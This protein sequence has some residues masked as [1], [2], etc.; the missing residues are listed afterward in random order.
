[1]AVSLSFR[2]FALAYLHAQHAS[3]CYTS[4]FSFGDSLADTGNLLLSTGSNGTR[5]GRLPYGETFFHSPTGRFSDGRLMIDFIAQA[6]GLPFVRPYLAGGAGGG[7]VNFAV[8]GA[9][10]LDVH[11]FESMGMEIKWTNYSL[12]AQLEWFRHLL[13]SLCSSA[14]GCAAFM[15]DALFLVGE[16]G[17]NDYNH[18][19]SAGRS[20]TEITAMVP[21]VVRAIT[22]AVDELIGMGV[23]TMVVPGNFP[24]GCSA[25]YLSRFQNE[26]RDSYDPRTGCIKWLNAFAEYHNRLLEEELRRLRC[27]HPD[28]IISYADYYQ[29]AME[30]YASPQDHGFGESPLAACCGSGGGDYNLNSTAGCGEEGSSVCSDPSRQISWDGLHLTEAAYRVIAGGLLGGHIMPSIARACPE[31]N[32]TVLDNGAGYISSS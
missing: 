28:V 1:M 18:A 27:R 12:S 20:L 6:M 2:L 4:I 16:I 31:L 17:G 22:S 11:Y 26:K 21:D 8:A 15:S 29:A 32:W 30:I 9:T 23:R 7:G 19:F 3:G 24:I 5:V 13:P 25:A 14:S 10:A